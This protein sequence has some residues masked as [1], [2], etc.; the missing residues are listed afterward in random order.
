[1]EPYRNLHYNG[2]MDMKKKLEDAYNP[3]SQTRREKV[4]IGLSGGVDSYVTA[5]LLK[6]QK[7]DLMAVT[8]LNSW[9]EGIVDQE[10]YFS[11]YVTPDK[12][13]KIKNFCHRMSIPLQIIKSSAEFKENV[14]EPWMADKALGKNSG[15]CWNCHELRMNLLYEKMKEAG[16]T[17]MATGH[18]AK[19]FHHE[20][21]DTVFVHTSNDELHDQSALLSR[22]SHDVLKGLLLPL[23]DLTRK[24]VMKLAENFGV[25]AEKPFV[26]MHE[27]LG[28]TPEISSLL[29]KK[30][31]KKILKGG[32]ITNLDG[33]MNL[34]HHEGIHTHSFGEKIELRENGKVVD[35]IFAAFAYSEKRMIV[36]DP[37][38]I[39]RSRISLINCHFSEDVSWPEPLKGYAVVSQNNIV[40]C[41]IYPKN[42]SAVYLEFSEK[43]KFLPGEIISVLKKKGKNSKVLLTGQVR[44]LPSEK[45]TTEGEESVPKVNPVTDF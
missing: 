34:G 12:L 39:K 11:C 37:D 17:K 20:A 2:I 9:D 35:G 42:M 19:L 31:P 16:A 38:Y 8:I 10:K 32:E 30:L 45:E 4:L 43:Y 1:M 40:E 3:D 26:R 33:G 18:Y 41:W 15:L 22:L 14:I 44:L 23:S 36:A 13:L 5:Y 27:C 21:H 25:I 7:Y 24:E 29:E 28:L 6:I